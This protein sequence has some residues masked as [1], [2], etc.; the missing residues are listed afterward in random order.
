MDDRGDAH[1][2]LTD[3]EKAQR[4]GSFGAVADLYERYRPGPPL[5]IVEWF[6]PTPVARAVDLGAGTGALTRLLAARADE[7][8]A[9][10]PDERMRAVLGDV[11]PNA[12]A[13]DGRGEAIPLGDGTA[14]A[15]AASSS[16]HWMHAR[17]IVRRAAR[18]SSA[19]RR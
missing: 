6:V 12:R 13:V 11:V 2:L 5:E 8:V 4:S 14:D 1:T 10:E 18:W 3:E 7:V 9:V 15:V 19:T 17:S 16:W